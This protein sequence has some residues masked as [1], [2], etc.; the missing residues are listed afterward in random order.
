[1]AFTVKSFD[2]IVADMVAYIVANSSQISDLTPGSVIRSYCEGAGLAL[3]ELYVAAYLGFRRYLGD[4]PEVVFDF[5]R[6]SGV[7]STVNVVFSRVGSSG[8]VTIPAGTRLLTPSGLR[9]ILDSA[10]VISD[11]NN[12]SSSTQVTAEET[13]LVYNVAL[14]TITIIEDPVSGVDTVTNA[15]AA[16]GGV[17]EETDFQY[18]TRFQA[19]V[20]GLGRSNIA[21]V[22]SGGLS[23]S[24]ITSASLTEHF[25]PISTPS[26]EA[27]Q[28]TSADGLGQTLTDTS[29]TF[30][31]TVRPGFTVV[32]FD[33]QSIAAV[34]SITSDT[35]LIHSALQDGSANDWGIS[36]YYK[37][38]DNNVNATLF[39]DD[40]T[41]GGISAAKL[42]EVTTVIDGDGTEDN[43][44]Y[45][46]AG[47][48]I[49]VEAPTTVT[50][51]VDVSIT[52]LTGID[53]SQV[54]TD[55]NTAL[56]GY[57]NSLGIDDDI[58]FNKLVEACMGVYGVTDCDVTDPTI[59]VVIAN[60]EVGRLGDVTVTF[61]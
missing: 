25:P 59:N 8:L 60:D 52:P 22:I 49:K 5:A 34:I 19:Y 26:V 36:D 38:Y 16:T 10:T 21:G 47:V 9:F 29:G 40:G 43:P 18:Q 33:D 42:L 51:D 17:N 55:I 54:E 14:S 4:I 61:V 1:M 28:A 56:T 44:G 30:L 39:V 11:G 48:N 2:T 41:S 53:Q 12:D 13:G 15:L 46:S 23:V 57:V 58:V 6:K 50:T 31:T 37:I 3:E 20:E 32:N 27:G 35:V 45:R 7:K 24:G